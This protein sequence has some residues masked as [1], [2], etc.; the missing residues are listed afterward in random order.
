MK[1]FLLLALCG[2]LLTV[3]VT[4]Q[5][6]ISGKVIDIDNN[7]D[8]LYG[9]VKLLQGDQLIQGTQTDWEG[10]YS[11]SSID[12]GTY[13]LEFSYVG[14]QTKRI[15]GFEAFM[16]K[17]N[18]MDVQMTGA[19]VDLAVIEIV[20]YEVPLIQQDNT[21]QGKTVTAKQI[22]NLPTKNINA[23]ASTTAGVGS[24]DEGGALTIRGQRSSGTVYI[25]DGVRTRNGLPPSSEISQLQVM[26]G[27]LPASVGDA[28]GGAISV[29]TKK[30][31][32]R[33]KVST[34]FETS[35]F[36]D[37]YG[38][39]F[40][41]VSVSGP[42][43]KGKGEGNKGTNILGFRAYG[44]IDRSED[45]DPTAGGRYRIKEAVFNDLSANP[46][47]LI[48]GIPTPKAE[49]LGEDDVELLDYNKNVDR[50]SYAVGAKLYLRI[51]SSMDFDIGGDYRGNERHFTPGG[52]NLLNYSNNPITKSNGIRG[53][54]RFKHR[55]SG[56]PDFSASATEG[57]EEE[58]RKKSPL[59]QNAQYAIQV[60]YDQGSGTT[61]DE[62]HEDRFFDY[63][64]VGKWDEAQ[65]PFIG[66][67]SGRHL[68]YFNGLNGYQ[69]N[70]N[71]NPGLAAYNNYLVDYDAK[72]D[73][74]LQNGRVP[75]FLS[76]YGT[77]TGV[78]AIYNSY[79]K[80][81]NN[82]YSLDVRGSFDINPGGK[83]GKHS[84]IFGLTYEQREDRSWT[85]NPRALWQLGEGLQNSH[86]DGID[87]LNV[88]GQDTLPGGELVDLYAN[89]F[90]PDAQGVFLRRVRQKLGLN[91][92][93]PVFISS[94]DDISVLS[95]D[96]FSSDELTNAN[97][98]GYYGYDYLGNKI[99]GEVTFDDF[100]TQRDETGLR[101]DRFDA[102]TKVLKDPYSLYEYYTASEF[103]SRNPNMNLKPSSLDNI[104][105]DFAVYVDDPSANT[106]TVRGY[107][108]GDV[109]Y[110]ANGTKVNDPFVIFG[111]E[112]ANPALVRPNERIK[113]TD[114]DPNT[115]FEDYKPELVW[116]PRLAFSFPISKDA[117]FFAHYDVLVQRPSNIL[118][119]PLTYY[120]F[121]ENTGIL[122]NPSLT[123]QKT[124]DYEVGFKKKVSRTSAITLAAYYREMRDMI[125]SRNFVYAYPKT[126]ESY[127][128]LD[129]GTSKGFSISYDMRRTNNVQLTASYTLQFADGTGSST[130]SQRGLSSR[131][132]IRTITPLSFDERHRL[133]AS[134]DYRYRSGKKYNG[135]KIAGKD[136]FANAGVNLQTTVVSGRPY[137]RAIVPQ[138]FGAGGIQGDL[139]SARLPWTYRLDLRVDKSFSLAKFGKEGTKKRPLEGNVYLRISNLLDTRNIIG[140]YRYT[141]SATD[142]GYLNTSDGQNQLGAAFDQVAA[143]NSYNW[144]LTN[145]DNFSL[146]RR[147]RLGARFDF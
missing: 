57:D 61:F 66:G 46:I 74:L 38:Y 78:N 39:N 139:N 137:T 11:F 65:I 20:A 114:Y 71:I 106:P 37:P 147:I 90:Q 99:G 133:S 141:G 131:G 81:E 130:T 55:I 56:T 21:T 138:R 124:V 8:V 2:F 142:D 92:A 101:V 44:Q 84:L 73:F 97:L 117:N 111:S 29:S 108:S 6:S 83:A 64:Y 146:P 69:G 9:T 15:E 25:V 43:I 59:I 82:Q 112:S 3:S 53:F 18:V 42:I 107:R 70:F 28:I 50:L 126:Y 120:Y 123:S 51:N 110:T 14:L 24:A 77:H 58:A 5:T 104:G 19:A 7:E 67:R 10:K 85:I 116:M 68:G 80:N 34:E 140:V 121:F 40:G 16:N 41:N 54:V 12:P 27:G 103:E 125:Q 102:N 79:N 118:A 132:N 144:A 96:L 47:T 87:T 30:P 94:L 60:G 72:S 105:D 127:G 122:N 36:L 134:I 23:I 119:T 115:S 52:W 31:S 26:I 32:P 128:N 35:Q 100:F 4:A 1:K 109:W 17:V 33:L 22:R 76:A 145:I 13:T 86:F 48:D 113:D 91:M 89:F 135:P 63:G 129:F 95:L 49:L 62:R 75:T 45:S 136:I 93:D 143:E 88:V 98:L